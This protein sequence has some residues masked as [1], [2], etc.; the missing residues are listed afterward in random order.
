MGRKKKITI[1][2]KKLRKMELLMLTFFV[3]TA[4]AADE[5]ATNDEL[6]KSNGDKYA[7]KYSSDIEK[8]TWTPIGFNESAHDAK[9]KSNREYLITGENTTFM[10]KGNAKRNAFQIFSEDGNLILASNMTL[11]GD[12]GYYMYRTGGYDWSKKS[13]AKQTFFAFDTKNRLVHDPHNMGPQRT[14]HLAVVQMMNTTIIR[15]ATSPQD[16]KDS[17]FCFVKIESGEEQDK[18]KKDGEMQEKNALQLQKQEEQPQ[19]S[20]TEETQQEQTEPQKTQQQQQQQKANTPPKKE[21][22]GSSVQAPFAI[23]PLAL[24]LFA[25]Y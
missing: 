25:T 1:E 22:P 15:E 24:L 13:N 11:F 12:N 6:V 16:I 20:A 2:S 21:D 14:F 7:L 18:D 5:C 8:F 9:D 17:R 4:F 3:T 10:I 23:C 19:K